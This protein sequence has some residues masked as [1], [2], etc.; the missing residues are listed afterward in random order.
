MQLADLKFVQVP[1]DLWQDTA[2]L[3]RPRALALFLFLCRT[4]ETK[5]HTTTVSYDEL[6][7]HLGCGRTALW[8]ELCWLE[9]HGRISRASTPWRGDGGL[10]RKMRWY[11]HF[12]HKVKPRPEKLPKSMRQRQAKRQTKPAPPRP[13][14][15]GNREHGEAVFIAVPNRVRKTPE[16]ANATRPQNAGKCGRYIKKGRGH[17]PKGEQESPRDGAQLEMFPTTKCGAEQEQQQG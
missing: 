5:N 12:P 10:F 6:S 9:A 16:N 17:A 14:N 2:L 13:Q 1:R 15:P 3:N 4:Q 7:A 8:K 11:L